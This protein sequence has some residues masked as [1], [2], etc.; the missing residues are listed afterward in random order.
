MKPAQAAAFLELG[1]STVRAWSLEFGSYL[2]STGA[3][4]EGRYRDFTE[5]DLRVLAF[6]KMLKYSGRA[7]PEVHAALKVLQ[8]SD[9]RDLPALPAAQSSAQFPVVPA[10]AADMALDE[11]RRALLREIAIL[12]ER[13]EDLEQ[14]LDAK[15][16]R[17]LE[18]ER[19]R[20][21]LET[22]VKLY[23]SGRLKPAKDE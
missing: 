13:I 2:S 11:Q 23:E 14:R 9:W 21:E 22:L 7:V 16:E 20:A 8:Q 1:T 15:D 18:S 3:G 17:L 5:H 4:G 10:V 12:Q 19:R 6:I